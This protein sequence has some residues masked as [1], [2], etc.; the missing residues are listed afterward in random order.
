MW[1]KI[2]SLIKRLWEFAKR[3]WKFLWGEDK[4]APTVPP[5]SEVSSPPPAV[6]ELGVGAAV[7]PEYRLS[8]SLFTYRESV[9][10]KTLL[11]EVKGQCVVFAKVRLADI[12]WLANEPE[13]HKYCTGQL[14]FEH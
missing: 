8:K 3:F 10:F 11:K 13:N 5:K 1:Q 4:V 6:R 2:V 14:D 12:I 7:P 9:F